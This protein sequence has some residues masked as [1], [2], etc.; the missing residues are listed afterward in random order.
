MGFSKL[1]MPRERLYADGQ[2][3]GV[4]GPSGDGIWGIQESLVI[5]QHPWGNS[6]IKMRSWELYS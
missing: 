3:G 4:A 6:W 5:H 1:Y 2:Q